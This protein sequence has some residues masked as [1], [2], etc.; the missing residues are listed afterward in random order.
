MSD[1]M[2]EQ[3]AIAPNRFSF[4]F[5]G[6][7]VDAEP[8]QS[9]AAALIASGRR[10]WRTTRR[11]GEPRGVFCGIGICFDCLATVNGRPNLRACVTPAQPGD[12]VV[13][14]D[15]TGHGDRAV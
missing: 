9:I 2:D 11:T 10:S 13:T 7:P 6:Q 4:T 3:P 8:G 15:G 1:P 14:Q 12:E 5:D